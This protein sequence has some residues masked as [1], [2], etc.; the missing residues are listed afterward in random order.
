LR[1]EYGT[2]KAVVH[3]TGNFED[4]RKGGRF[5]LE[6]A[7]RMPDVA[8]FIVGNREPVRDLP[9]NVQA[10]GRTAD[11]SELAGWYGFAD[12]SL[13]TSE[14]ENLPTVCLESLCCGTPV[15]GFVG[16]GT[17]E[18]APDGY[19]AFVPYADLAALEDA[20]RNA[21]GGALRGSDEC[22]AFGKARYAKE[23]MAQRYVELYEGRG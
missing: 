23:E 8:F 21:L 7:R 19:G 6:L 22:A 13:I 12:V 4:K 18:T 15:V 20:T 3:V 11:Q 9:P 2:Q 16:G 10:V 14:R 17:A 1:E 5:V